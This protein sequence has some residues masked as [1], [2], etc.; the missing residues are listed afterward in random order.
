MTQLKCNLKICIKYLKDIRYFTQNILLIILFSI[1]F[2]LFYAFNSF[3]IFMHLHITI[4][5]HSANVY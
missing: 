2:Q 5:T 3:I 1:Y 4:I